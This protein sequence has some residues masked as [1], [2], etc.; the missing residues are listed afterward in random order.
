MANKSIDAETHG[1]ETNQKQVETQPSQY[2]SI[3]AYRSQP[4]DLTDA[5]LNQWK[6][7]GVACKRMKFH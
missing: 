7:L 3:L 5:E 4:E 6:S 1:A 2:E